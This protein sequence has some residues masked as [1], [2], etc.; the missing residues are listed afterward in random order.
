M[1]L[2]NHGGSFWGIMG[3][4]FGESLKAGG[5]VTA[6]ESMDKGEQGQAQ[7]LEEGR[8]R[9]S[10]EVVENGIND[11]QVYLLGPKCE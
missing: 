3:D 7:D 4:A 10:W 6:G 1:H 9:R 11:V 2:G 8:R 5:K